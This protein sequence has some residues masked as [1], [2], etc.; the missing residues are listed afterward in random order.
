MMGHS[1]VIVSR[2]KP[3]ALPS[4]DGGT[5]DPLTTLTVGLG[6]SG[7][8]FPR[9][10]VSAHESPAAIQRTHPTGASGAFIAEIAATIGYDGVAT[11]DPESKR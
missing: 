3:T 6:F 2:P 1:G 9:L 4:G 10:A 5:G 11:P 7:A 8:D